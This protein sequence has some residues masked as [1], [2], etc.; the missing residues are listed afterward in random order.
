MGILAYIPGNTLAHKLYPVTKLAWLLIAS[1]LLFIL[2]NGYFVICIASVFF[3]L[4]MAI[5]PQVWKLRGFR[6][7]LG[8][9]LTLFILYLLFIKGGQILLNPGIG[10]LR[11]TTEG[12]ATGL[13]YCGRF[14]TIIFLSMIFILTT[15]P[16]QLA[17]ALMQIGIPYRFGFMLVTALRLAP[18]MEQE[19]QTIYHAQ[20]VRGIRYDRAG[21]KKLFLLI[22]QF[23]TPMLIN[24]LRRADRLYFS[25]EGRGFGQSTHRTFRESIQPTK[26]DFYCSLGLILFFSIVIVLDIGLL[27]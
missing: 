14:F 24:A 15:N 16:S 21:P 27:P 8:T 26:L 2:S 23:L 12:I 5:Q 25:M 17:Y 6:F 10:F 18:L 4:L 1:F 7:V 22:Q 3:L 13:L 20:L 9:G 19:G 11:I